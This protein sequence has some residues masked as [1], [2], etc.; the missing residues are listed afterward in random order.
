MSNIK[1]YLEQY[2]REAAL[3]REKNRDSIL[4]MTD[5]C[6]QLAGTE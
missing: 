4:A 2:H 1:E 6:W 5:S 3:W